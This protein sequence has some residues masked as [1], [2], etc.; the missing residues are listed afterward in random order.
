M[1]NIKAIDA[2]GAGTIREPIVVIASLL[3]IGPHRSTPML[4]PADIG[5][6]LIFEAVTLWSMHPAAHPR[7]GNLLFEGRVAARSVFVT[8]TGRT[9][10]LK[11]V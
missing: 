2:D 6:A 11:A 9:N 3:G 10:Y 5:T 7:I 4:H 1:N 8:P